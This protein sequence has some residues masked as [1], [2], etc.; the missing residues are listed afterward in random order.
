MSSVI[1]SSSKKYAVLIGINYFGTSAELRG[2]I[3]DTNNLKEFLIERCNYLPENILMLTDNNEDNKPTKQNIKN[4]FDLL[5]DKAK[6]EEFTELWLSYSGH[7]SYKYDKSGDEDDSYDEVLCPVDYSDS[8]MITDDYIYKNLISLLP[9]DVTLFSLMDCCHSGTI[10]D[11]PYIYK[12]SV[13]T[14]NSNSHEATVISISGCRDDQTS[15]DSY[16]NSGYEGA[17]TWSFLNAL[18]HV[19]YKTTIK[20]LVERMRA[21]LYHN[22]TQV[23]MLAVSSPADIDR[24]LIEYPSSHVSEKDV[25]FTMTVDY[26]YYESSWNVKNE[27]SGEKIF[28]EDQTFDSKYQTTNTKVKLSP[29][30]YRLIVNDTY[31][32][33]GITSLVTCGLLKL[34]S[35]KMTS[36]SRG[37]YLFYV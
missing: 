16:I 34:L 12:D 17:M 32:D 33:G 9:S 37:E 6:N 23:P 8:G 5:V 13:K 4:S 18:Y 11:L 22:Y 19:N 35:A 10:L 2:C 29:G 30:F 28:S 7:G 3:N 20:N 36:G 31:G 24:D 26:W 14:N 25:E 21:L 15:A 1:S 27:D